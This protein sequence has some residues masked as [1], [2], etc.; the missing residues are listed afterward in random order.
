MAHRRAKLTP[1]G[2]LLIV[3]RVLELGWTATEAAKAAG[4]S[5]ATAHKWVRRYREEGL[6]GL[7]DRSS[8]ARRCPHALPARQ[9]QR[10]LRARRR[11]KCGPH[12]L[13]SVVGSPRST[14][15]AVLR[16]HQMSRLAHLDRP[17]G[18]PIRYERERPG[19][20]VHVD[21]KKLGRIPRG[22]GW[23]IRGRSSATKHRGGGYDYLHAAVDDHSRVAYV[24]VHSDERGET[25]AR[26]LASASAFFAEYGV[27]IEQVMTDNALNYVRSDAFGTTMAALGLTHVRIPP[28]RPRANGKVERFN[29]TLAEEWAYRRLY[30]SN[31]ER[32][33]ALGRWVD[34]YN[35]RRSH[36]ALGD[37]PPISRL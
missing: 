36:T 15:Y 31:P 37:R 1:F 20:L 32:L 17:T 8:R 25:C 10:I 19:E 28:Y 18:T 3:Q 30:R 34:F 6:G 9:V 35:H 5:R 27:R 26:F 14:V 2:R 11:L 4:V 7:E 23:R 16:R 12:Q 29:R 24:E 21:V 13:A 22:G 33:R